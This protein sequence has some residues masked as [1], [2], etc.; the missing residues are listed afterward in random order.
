MTHFHQLWH[1]SQTGQSTPF[2]G[3][4]NANPEVTRVLH[5]VAAL[6]A[7]PPVRARAEFVKDLRARLVAETLIP[8]SGR[9]SVA[10]SHS[11]NEQGT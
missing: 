2:F 6:R 3:D 9:L 8:A 4:Q 11:E 5:M 7:V 1:E 10:A